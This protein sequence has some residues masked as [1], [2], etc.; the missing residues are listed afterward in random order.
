M[1]K[2]HRERWPWL[3]LCCRPTTDSVGKPNKEAVLHWTCAFSR[4]CQFHQTRAG[5]QGIGSP[6]SVS[7]SASSHFVCCVCLPLLCLPSLCLRNGAA[8]VGRNVGHRHR[9][10][11]TFFFSICKN[12]SKNIVVWFCDQDFVEILQGQCIAKLYSFK[13]ETFN[14]FA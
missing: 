1:H 10:D 7:P 9:S 3:C 2:L 6:S 8:E 13:T 5:F 4:L 12:Y 11:F 14:E